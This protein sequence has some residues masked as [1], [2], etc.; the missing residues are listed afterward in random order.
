MWRVANELENASLEKLF[1]EVF[2]LI[3][4]GWEFY[5][6]RSCRSL[7]LSDIESSLIR[8]PSNLQN[9]S[10][11]IFIFQFGLFEGYT[12]YFWPFYAKYCV[13]LWTKVNC[14][15]CCLEIMIKIWILFEVLNKALWMKHKHKFKFCKSHIVLFCFGP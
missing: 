7:M 11:T 5:R 3:K 15:P 13:T 1:Y 10:I 4:W 2:N 8:K 14:F 6:T 9:T 12:T